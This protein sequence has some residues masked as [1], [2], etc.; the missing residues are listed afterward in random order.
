MVKN[1]LSGGSAAAAEEGEHLTKSPAAQPKSPVLRQPLLSS[2]AFARLRALCV[3]RDC[4]A[5]R[6][7]NSQG[8]LMKCRPDSSAPASVECVCICS[9]ALQPGSKGRG[10]LCAAPSGGH[11]AC[12]GCWEGGLEGAGAKRAGPVVRDA[13]V[14]VRTCMRHGACLRRPGLCAE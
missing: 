2:P 10:A 4:D 3:A 6:G 8:L 14:R 12:L 7:Q 5:S 11:G 9:Y 1:P 13:C